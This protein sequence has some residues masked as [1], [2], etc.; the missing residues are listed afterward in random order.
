MTHRLRW[1]VVALV[2][3]CVLALALALVARHRSPAHRAD[4][5]MDDVGD[6]AGVTSVVVHN[7]PEL[8][9]DEPRDAVVT[10]SSQ[11][12]PR[13]IRRV[14]VHVGHMADSDE[15]ADISVRVGHAW[16]YSGSTSP[17]TAA[18]LSAL[19]RLPGGS[20]TVF[21]A[22]VRLDPGGR[23]PISLARAAAGALAAREV[24]TKLTLGPA[25]RAIV[26]SRVRMS[27]T[28]RILDT[29]K[30]YAG[31][32]TQVTISDAAVNITM[33]TST[34]GVAKTVKAVQPTARSALG[35]GVVTRVETEGK[36]E[37]AMTGRGSGDT[38]SALSTMEQLQR[39]GWQVTRIGSDRREITVTSP[40]DELSAD[41]LPDLRR[42]LKA[43]SPAVPRDADLRVGDFPTVFGGTPGQLTTM[44]PKLARVTQ[45]GYSV[46]W[47]GGGDHPSVRLGLPQGKTLTSSSLVEASR[48]VR[49]L[50]WKGVANVRIGETRF[51]SLGHQVGFQSTARGR[52][53]TVEPQGELQTSAVK[54][55]WNGTAPR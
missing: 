14:L 21:G 15:I 2:F 8:E 17:S 31:Q 7:Y 35:P 52:L 26:S 40:D 18:A 5:A 34:K 41:Q 23:D 38:D 12:R 51:K 22:E 25:T 29:L 9:D 13:D 32:V 49:S 54:R 47:D 45:R 46:W 36:N 48:V 19:A 44:A 11:A 50:P 28:K 6:L 4:A 27:A 10:M 16:A 30:P 43:L 3:V 24:N 20:A 37:V 39:K 55:A 42:D 33:L 53:S 1:V